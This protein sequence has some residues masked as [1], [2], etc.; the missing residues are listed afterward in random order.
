MCERENERKR[1]ETVKNKEREGGMRQCKNRRSKIDWT[2]VEG[3]RIDSTSTCTSRI[4][5]KAQL[6]RVCHD[7]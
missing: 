7:R 1:G 4:A 6:G 5:V 3:K 2:V